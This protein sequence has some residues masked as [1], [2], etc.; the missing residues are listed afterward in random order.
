MY[1]WVYL[2]FFNMLWV[3]IPLYAIWYS[4]GQISNAFNSETSE[5]SAEVTNEKSKVQK[6]R[7]V[8]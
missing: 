2:I 6:K 8:A 4:V 3:F 5:T 1:L 7:K